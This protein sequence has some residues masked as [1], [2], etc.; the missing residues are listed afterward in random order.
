MGRPAE[1]ATRAEIA[2][3]QKRYRRARLQ[4]W[5]IFRVEIK[6]AD[7]KRPIYFVPFTHRAHAS[8]EAERQP[9]LHIE[10]ERGVNVSVPKQFLHAWPHRV[11]PFILSLDGSLTKSLKPGL[12]I[13]A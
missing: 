6:H 7:T 9:P 10:N 13:V 4:W 3:E 8:A 5:Q 1:S 2:L 12:A 11:V